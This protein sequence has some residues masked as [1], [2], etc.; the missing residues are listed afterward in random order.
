MLTYCPDFFTCQCFGRIIE[1]RQ[2][3]L[4]CNLILNHNLFVSHPP[5]QFTEDKI[6][7]N[8]CPCNDRFTKTHFLIDTNSCGYFHS[9]SSDL[10]LVFFLSTA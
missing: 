6:N 8:S 10:L 3:I 2:Y 4:A 7:R 1:S 5:C 9:L